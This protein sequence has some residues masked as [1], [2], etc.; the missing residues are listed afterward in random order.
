MIFDLNQSVDR[1]TIKSDGTVPNMTRGAVM[2][3]MRACRE[4]TVSEMAKLL[5]QDLRKADLQFTTESQM[6]LMLGMGMH[7]ATAGF[8]LAGLLAAVGADSQSTSREI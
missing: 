2:W 3:S 4:L 8:A 5:G 6:R 1:R 7:V